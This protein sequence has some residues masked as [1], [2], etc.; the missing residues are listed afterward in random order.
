MSG[1][2]RVDPPS[3]RQLAGRLDAV[4]SELSAAQQSVLGSEIQASAFSPTGQPLA[5]AFLAAIEYA[6][7]DAFEQAD[8]VSSIQR[9]L[10]ST[11]DLWEATEEA[12]TVTEN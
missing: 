9:R 11:A 3:L 4:I 5:A 1:E 10:S 8:Q 2:V 12:S 6:G 7:N